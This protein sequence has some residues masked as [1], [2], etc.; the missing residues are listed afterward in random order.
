MLKSLRQFR[1]TFPVDAVVLPDIEMQILDLILPTRPNDLPRQTD[2]KSCFEVNVL[3]MFGEIRYQERRAPNFSD[4][5]VIDFVCV[6]LLTN[7]HRR[8]A[9][10]AYGWFES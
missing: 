4:D 10:F 2:R 3:A 7:E 9:S 8:E 5:L 6:L 1:R